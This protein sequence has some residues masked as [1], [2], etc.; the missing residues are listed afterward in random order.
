MKRGLL[1]LMSFLFALNV[2]A[3]GD[4]QPTSGNVEC[5]KNVSYFTVHAKSKNYLDA[6]TFWKKVYDACPTESKNIYIYGPEILRWKI[7]QAKTPEEKQ[8][9]LKELLEVYDNRIKYFGDDPKIGKDYIMGSK[10]QDYMAIMGD[11]V[12]YDLIYSW[13]KPVVDEFKENTDPYTLSQFIYSSMARMIK[14]PDLKSKYVDDH[15]MV[16]GYFDT[17]INKANEC[18]DDKRA[19]LVGTYKSDAQYFFASSGAA[20]CDMMQQIYG[21]L[22][23]DKKN[24]K[25]YLKN[26]LSV[27]QSVGCTESN[28]YFTASEYMYQLEPT[29]NAALGMAQKA[30]KEK[31]Y[32][33]ATKYFE[34]A[35]KLSDSGNDRGNAYY[36]LAVM[37]YD[38]NSYSAARNYANKAMQEKSGF[39]APMLLIA[40]M[41]AATARSI[42]PDDPI[43]QR[44]VYCLVVD[45]CER[46]RAMDPSV[47]GEAARAIAKYRAHFP[48]KEDVFMHPDLQEGS[49]FFVGGWIGESTTIRTN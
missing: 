41:Y 31:N 47:A 21:P 5:N 6:Y 4:A 37:S 27:L 15:L 40:N 36:M 33:R 42:F 44:I 19:E 11:S 24:D 46:A 2:L 22:I 9:F 43:K 1:L 34:E 25:E 3:Q 7:E 29:A 10:V 30:Y 49:S 8:A 12:D 35:I 38:R 17:I 45:K 16:D 20:S 48:S 13:L 32:D 23:G 18:G 28:V 14:N 39:G 26:V